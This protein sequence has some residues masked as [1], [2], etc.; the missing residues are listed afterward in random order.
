ERDQHKNTYDYSRSSESWQ[1]SPSSPLEQKRQSVIQEIIATEATYLK[2]L[3]LVE[4]AFIS[5]MR[6]SGIIT[7]K[8]LDLL[9]ANWNELILV[10]S[11]FN[12]ALK[13]RRMNSSGGVIT[14]IADVL[15]QQ[16]SQLTPYLRFC[17]I[18]IRGATL[19][20]EK[21]AAGG[22]WADL[23]KHCQEHP[24]VQ[25]LTLTAFLL[26]P[27]QRITRYPLLIKQLLKY[28][29]EG[30]PDNFNTQE[31]LSASETLCAQVN[32]AVSHRDNTDKL[33][34]MQRHVTCEGLQ[35]RLVFNSLT[36]ILGPRK[37]L[38]TGVLHK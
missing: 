4:Q 17:S 26:K 13:V 16:I 15:C 34:F 14:M 37:L 19:L 32:E 1:F 21:C 22:A 2:E 9:F 28:T 24:A 5:P 23:V 25:G 11:Y 18:Q 12:K 3:L 36:N 27:M 35:E 30:H 20:G 33:E 38:H 31:A 8:Q 6:A 7:E 10:N 29:P